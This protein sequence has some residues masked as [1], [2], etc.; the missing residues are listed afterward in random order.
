MVVYQASS[1]SVFASK[2]CSVGEI[3]A[4][5][6]GLV[7]KGADLRREISISTW[8]NFGKKTVL[9]PRLSNRTDNFL[10]YPNEAVRVKHR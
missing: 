9:G 8:R 2:S 10:V 7:V 4:I 6:D 3:T 1:G 5:L